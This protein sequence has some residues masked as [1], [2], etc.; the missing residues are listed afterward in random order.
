MSNINL[1]QVGQVNKPDF[2]GYILD[3]VSPHTGLAGNTQPSGVEGQV[4]FKSGIYFQGSDLYYISGNLGFG[5][6]APS[7]DFHFSGKNLLVNA[8]GTFDKLLVG[9][10]SVVTETALNA[11]GSFLDAATTSLSGFVSSNYY[12]TGYTEATYYPRSNPSGYV[13]SGQTGTFVTDGQISGIILSGQTGL[14]VTS[15]QTGNFVTQGQTGSYVTS[16]QTGNFIVDNGT[17]VRTG[18]TG[19]FVTD[20]QIANFVNQSQTGLVLVGKDETGIFVT[21]EQSGLFQPSGSYVLT[22]QT[23]TYVTVGQ[24]GSFLANHETGSL[25]FNHHTGSFL[26]RHETGVL[27]IAFVAPYQT[28]IFLTTGETGAYS[29]SFVSHSQTGNFITNDQTGAFGGGGGGG[30]IQNLS[31]NESTQTLAI[32]SG[33]SASLGMFMSTGEADNRYAQISDTGNFVTTGQTGDFVGRGETG[34]YVTQGQTGSWVANHETGSMSGSF[35][36]HSQTGNYSSLFAL[37]SKTGIFVTTGQT[38]SH[39]GAA[40]PWTEVGSSYVSYAGDI[41]GQII[42]GTSG[43]FLNRPFVG[44][45]GLVLMSETGSFGG[46]GGGGGIQNLSFNESTQTLAITSGTSASLGMFMSTGEADGRYAQVSN[47]GNFVTLGQTGDFV[48]RGETGTYVTQ[49]QTGSWVANHE[50]VALS[51]SFVSHSQTGIFVTTG[52]TGSHGGSSPWTDGTSYVSYAGGVSGYNIS[53]ISGD[54]IHKVN[55]G[56][57]AR[58]SSASID[59]SSLTIHG[60]DNPSINLKALGGWSD[61]KIHGGV[62]DPLRIEN[63]GNNGNKY[64]HFD[65][66]YVGPA[67]GGGMSTFYTTSEIPAIL[68]TS[69]S[70]IAPIFRAKYGTEEIFSFDNKGRVFFGS[71]GN[72]SFAA[73]VFISG[74]SNHTYKGIVYKQ[75]DGHSANVM[76]L[77]DSGNNSL[78]T[79]A[80]NFDVGFGTASPSTK[81]HVVGNI[82]GQIISGT[83]G[84][85]LNR[86]YVG[87]DGLVLMSE[88]GSFGGGASPWTEV[89]SSY[90]SYAGDV[91]GEDISGR[92]LDIVG[93]G[94]NGSTDLITAKDSASVERFV[95]N[96]AGRITLT[97]PSGGQAGW[98]DESEGYPINIQTTMDTDGFA[99]YLYGQST[100]HGISD[101]RIFHSG[102]NPYIRGGQG[103]FIGSNYGDILRISKTDSD[104]GTDAVIIDA[105]YGTTNEGI[106]DLQGATLQT[107]SGY[108]LFANR[109]VWAHQHTSFDNQAISFNGFANDQ[110]VE[111]HAK[112]WRKMV[113]VNG[114]QTVPEVVINENGYSE[115][116]FRVEATGQPNALFVRG[117]DGNVGIATSAPAAKLHVVGDI[118]GQI[119][120]GAGISNFGKLE[121]PSTGLSSFDGNLNI[122]F[123]GVSHSKYDI[124]GNLSIT[125]FQNI[126]N[127]RL[128]TVRISGDATNRVIT[129]DPLVHYLG[130]APTGISA[131]KIMVLSYTCFGQ[132]VDEIVGCAAAEA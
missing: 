95:V 81:L 98:A 113:N 71:T 45:D 26:A 66:T 65:N 91:S 40:S 64:V 59:S 25:V 27:S 31:F 54:F 110:G 50:T 94:T 46:G 127:G 80:N 93:E 104:A 10:V 68:V 86:P 82:T 114:S 37:N 73:Q 89:G 116:D 34:T 69:S 67:I 48:G 107:N 85:F 111:L 57:S 119:I 123:G 38:G 75:R 41:T 42:S 8:T 44:N 29:G 61:W 101:I 18:Q 87:N 74:A 32:T 77:R 55:I 125:G 15:G 51:G 92:N 121:L 130:T 126:S 21:T 70:N 35:V 96:D 33:T 43:N 11:S 58:G 49:G 129:S 28:G 22:G 83:S 3:V 39:G 117:S 30:G 79:V 47:T 106:F 112:T 124:D 99:P 7:E 12:Q 78:V 1:I 84:N 108:R 76:E 103:L 62:N 100:N 5:T 97:V 24:T 88:T 102:Y 109:G 72:A 115:V 2:S 90:V 6:T 23:G 53:G 19:T 20:G 118:T 9:N 105:G 16:G 14:F 63:I 4:Q 13:S 17:Y 122:D 120:S 131:N 36:S 128:H 132:G 52:Q 56:T 60:Y